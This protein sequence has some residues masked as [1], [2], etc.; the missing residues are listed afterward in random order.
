[1]ASKGVQ[2]VQLFS[3]CESEYIFTS[4]CQGKAKI[5]IF[6]FVNISVSVGSVVIIANFACIDLSWKRRLQKLLAC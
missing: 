6:G 1:M 5:V 2:L 4:T 3:G